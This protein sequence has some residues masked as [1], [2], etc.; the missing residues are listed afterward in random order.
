ML[1]FL[2]IITY[3]FISQTKLDRNNI[4]EEQVEIQKFLATIFG[5]KKSIIF[6]I[7][8]IS[9]SLVSWPITWQ[10]LGVDQT[11]PISKIGIMWTPG[12][13]IL[14]SWFLSILFRRKKV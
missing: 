8:L 7:V 4:N 13:L 1:P 6:F 5:S 9:T 2:I 11:N 14:N 3:G 10:L 12:L